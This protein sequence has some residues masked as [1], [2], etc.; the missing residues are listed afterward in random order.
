MKEENSKEVGIR[1]LMEPEVEEDLVWSACL[2]QCG[3]NVKVR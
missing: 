2:V 3:C 1:V